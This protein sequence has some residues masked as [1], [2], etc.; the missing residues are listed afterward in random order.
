MP[1]TERSIRVLVVDDQVLIRAGLVALLN[2]APG[3]E[4]VGEA[5][6]GEAAVALAARVRPQVILMDIRM[7]GAGGIAATR[8]ILATTDDGY[9]PHVL[10]LTTFDLDEY[11]YEALKAGASGFLLKDSPPERL[12]NAVATVA[13]G[14]LLFAP[15]VVRGLIEAY[16]AR[17][18]PKPSMMAGSEALT[19]REVDVLRLVARGRSNTE[20][21]EHL[22]IAEATVKTHL[23]RTMTKL[24]LSSRA[25]AVVVA[26]ESGLVVPQH[27]GSAQG[28]P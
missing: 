1:S 13:G 10:I 27:G 25:Q 26:Y 9:R 3:I 8:R 17:A 4:V 24:G 2:A 23:N 18:A 20:I 21:A 7:P 22:V 19:G 15:S 6:D 11:V 14:D 28:L 12:I 5:A 16:A